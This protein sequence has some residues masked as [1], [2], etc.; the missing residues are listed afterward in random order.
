MRLTYR[1]P[2][3][4]LAVAVLPACGSVQTENVA[5]SG[6][7]TACAD[8]IKQRVAYTQRCPG[9]DYDGDID[10]KAAVATCIGVATAPGSLLTIGDVDA[11]TQALGEDCAPPL[12]PSCV[13]YAANLLYPNHDKHGA[14]LPGAACV[15]HLQ[16]ASGYCSATDASCGK[17]LI[18][19]EVGEACTGL[20]DVCTGVAR[21]TSG[22][23]ELPGDPEGATCINYG[24]PCQSNLYCNASGG[25]LNGVCTALPGA[26]APCAMGMCG[27]DLACIAQ[28]CVALLPDGASCN[29]MQ[30]CKNICAGGVC[31]T[32]K[33]VGLN[34]PCDFDT[35]M[36]GLT[37]SSDPAHKVCVVTVVT[38]KGGTCN[39]A[40]AAPCAPS[41][42]CDSG[43]GLC[44][45][46]PGQGQPCVPYGICAHGFTCEGLA[47]P[48][49]LGVCTRL[50]EVGDPCPCPL[51]LAC[52][53]GKCVAYGA[54]VCM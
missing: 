51:E 49:Q 31:R 25:G 1:L 22:K 42:M 29:G 4:V 52:V 43:T 45:D 6:F 38:P 13:G 16:C 54:A 46:Y 39:T 15:A 19:R 24:I 5:T 10:P 23:C 35:C 41:L 40:S 21:C 34:A 44:A 53:A 7:A 9:F 14:G 2:L 26:G 48:Q 32:A 20:L 11:C 28:V 17:C 12:Y 50:G 30:P 47:S 27:A 37:C 18:P 33:V 36:P 3:A 8:L